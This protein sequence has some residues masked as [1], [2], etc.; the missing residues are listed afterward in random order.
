MSLTNTKRNS[1]LEGLR[2]IFIILMILHHLDMFYPVDI[3]SFTEN[4]KKICFEFFIGV[5]FFFMLSGVGC[6]VGYKQKLLNNSVSGHEFIKKRL[7]NIWPTYL[8]FILTAIFLFE[9]NIFDNLSSF[10]LNLFMLQSFPIQG[11]V[12][13][14]YNA[15]SWCISDLVF[16]YLFFAYLGYLLTFK[17]CFYITLFLLLFVLVNMIFFN[18]NNPTSMFYTS[19]CFRLLEF[20]CGMCIALWFE[21]HEIVKSYKLQILS[22]FILLAFLAYGVYGNVPLMYRW[23]VYYLFPFILLLYSF[24]GETRWSKI[25]LGNGIMEK[26]SKATIVIYLSHQQML[27]I[28][29]T[30][31]PNK[32]LIEFYNNFIPLGIFI[33]C[34]MIVLGSYIL[35]IIYTKPIKNI[36]QK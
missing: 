24:Y 7:Q 13:F 25:V 10:L 22:I 12:P 19:P 33:A 4:A 2:L 17:N 20:L 21:K 27:Y 5:N 34:S 28:I 35:Y 30:C 26:L 23:S 6:V 3:P 9:I 1:S 8:L 14:S 32:Y 15:V 29:K 31:L 18:G 36:L 11:N 16:F